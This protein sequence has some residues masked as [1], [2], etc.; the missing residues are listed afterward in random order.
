MKKTRSYKLI[1]IKDP[2]AA[3]L[4]AAKTLGRNLDSYREVYCG[5]D[6]EMVELTNCRVCELCKGINKTTVRCA[7]YFIDPLWTPD[8]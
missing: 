7:W 3:I 8:I 4:I 2:Q 1:P 6:D 5:W